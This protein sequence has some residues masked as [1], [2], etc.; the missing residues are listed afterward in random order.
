[1]VRNGYLAEN[2]ARRCQGEPIRVARRD[3]LK[4]DAPAAVEHVLDELRRGGVTGSRLEDLFQGRIE[5]HS[6]VDARV[7]AIVNEALER[8]LAAYEE[9]HPRSRGLVQG[10]VVVL[11]NADAAILAEV[12]GRR[13]YGARDTRYSDYNRVTGSLR[14]PGSAMKPLVYMAAFAAGMGLDTEVPDEPI[15]VP[16]GSDGAIKWIANYDDEFK[17]PI[18][19]RQALAESRNA[20]AVWLTREIGVNRVLD[21]AAEMG[22]RTPLQPYL[23]TAL[24]ASRCGCSSWR[25]PIEPSPRESWPSRMSSIG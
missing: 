12:G 15:A 23:S 18:P 20:V 7:Q 2:L 1:M 21:T 9:R 14:Q 13:V 25:T 4:T 11:A 24:G 22:I 8:G 19:L 6:T 5:V 16:D 17:G 3:A 10:S